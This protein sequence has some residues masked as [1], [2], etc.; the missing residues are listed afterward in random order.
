L[1][2]P[3]LF[4][5]P[6][7][8]PPDRIRN[9]PCKTCGAMRPDGCVRAVFL[10]PVSLECLDCNHATLAEIFATRAVDRD[11]HEAAWRRHLGGKLPK[12]LRRAS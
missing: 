6:T 3:T 5:I 7:E 1:T 9:G 12:G 8:E 4:D 11:R 10:E 2:A